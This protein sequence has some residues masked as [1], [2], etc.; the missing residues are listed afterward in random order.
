MQ[1]D[2]VAP[3]AQLAFKNINVSSPV[4]SD[5][6]QFRPKD[7]Y[8]WSWPAV[9]NKAELPSS[10]GPKDYSLGFMT[11]PTLVDWLTLNLRYS[12]PDYVTPGEWTRLT[13]SW[14]NDRYRNRVW[15]QFTK[16]EVPPLP[17]LGLL[18]GP[19]D[20]F[21]TGT[22]FD[23]PPNT[24]WTVALSTKNINGTAPLTNYNAYAVQVEN[25]QCKPE[26]CYVP[27][28]PCGTGQRY[29]VE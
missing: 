2:N 4:G 10:S 9:V 12:E 11:S 17:S 8:G 22:W 15:F 1:M 21:G 25:I 18:P 7:F 14:L 5:V 20:M 23:D 19:L 24:T 16:V 28:P 27:P 13:F 26:G 3:S 29:K 6:V